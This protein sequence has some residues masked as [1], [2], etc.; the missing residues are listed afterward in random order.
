MREP[1]VPEKARKFPE[2]IP[3]AMNTCKRI[4]YYIGEG[5]EKGLL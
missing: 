4:I 1:T 2:M 5:F 3:G